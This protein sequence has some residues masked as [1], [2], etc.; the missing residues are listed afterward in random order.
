[1]I[2]VTVLVRQGCQTCKSAV[3]ILHNLEPEFDLKIREVLVTS[4][5]GEERAKRHMVAAIPAI[6]IDDQLI[7]T[8]PI[9]KD[10]LRIRL[11]EYKEEENL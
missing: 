11:N 5:E 1:M 10:E 2:E 3:Q 4:Q 7:F 9:T 6:I 8:G